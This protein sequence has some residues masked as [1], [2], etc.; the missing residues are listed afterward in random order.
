MRPAAF[1]QAPVSLTWQS[2]ACPA[3][4]YIQ[5]S[6]PGF[7]QIRAALLIKYYAFLIFFFAL[8]AVS[9]A[10]SFAAAASSRRRSMA[11]RVAASVSA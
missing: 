8:A 2:R 11:A 5:Q 4:I 7:P 10:A 1:P 6:R 9:L 3:P